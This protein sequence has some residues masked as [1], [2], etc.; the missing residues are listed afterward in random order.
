MKRKLLALITLVTLVFGI[1]TGA[2]A[3]V[4]VEGNIAMDDEYMV[5][6]G[7]DYYSDGEIALYLHA[8]AQLPPNFITKNEAQ[9]MGWSSRDGNLW[10]V[11]Y[12]LCIGG[13]VF[14]NR[15]G[16][17]PKQSGR[18]YYECDANYDGGY[19]DAERLVFS[20]DGLIY[21]TGDHYESFELLYEGFY[22]EDAYYVSWADVEAGR[23]EFWFIPD[24]N[25]GYY[26]YGS[27]SYRYDQEDEVDYGW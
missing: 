11:A 21:Y 14:G 27:D 24:E 23:A 17:L 6:Y 12:G 8:F 5:E 25:A 2:L 3:E 20:D 13:D 16:L 26:G 4:I 10:E 19:R 9:D 1:F 18:T 7:F 22:S 15:E